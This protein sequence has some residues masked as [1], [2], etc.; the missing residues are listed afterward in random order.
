MSVVNIATKTDDNGKNNEDS[1]F[2]GRSGD[3]TVLCVCDG[4]GGTDAGEIASDYVIKSLEAWL[5]RVD[6]SRFGPKAL[7]IEVADFIADMHE[8]LLIHAES[9][10]KDGWDDYSL[11]TTFVLAV[12]GKGKAIIENIGDSRAYVCQRDYL[13]QITVDQT[14]RVYEQAGGNAVERQDKRLS[15]RKKDSTLMWCVGDGDICPEP[16]TYIVTLDED[17]DILLCSDGLS[18]KLNELN[19]Q[20]QLLKKQSGENVL[21]NLI[22]LAKKRGERD[23]ITAVLFRR[24]KSV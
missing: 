19:F 9:K 1:F 5:K 6:I 2:V 3:K 11:G 10:R 20:S 22:S 24:R 21:D 7:H 13:K 4:V 14:V 16:V 12:I 15:G 23:N 8:D 18:N 17:V